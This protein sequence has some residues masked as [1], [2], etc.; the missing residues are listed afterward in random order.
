[1]TA[2]NSCE[3]YVACYLVKDSKS[4]LTVIEFYKFAVHFLSTLYANG[5]ISAKSARLLSLKKSNK[6]AVSLIFK[7]KPH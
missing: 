1:M 4:N 6:N 3:L 2:E 7:E 5:A